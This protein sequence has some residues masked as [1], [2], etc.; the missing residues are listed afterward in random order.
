MIKIFK[1]LIVLQKDIFDE[2]AL[3]TNK[4]VGMYLKKKNFRAY[5]GVRLCHSYTSDICIEIRHVDD[6]TVL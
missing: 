5:R 1:Y 3:V 2:T 4:T 6:I